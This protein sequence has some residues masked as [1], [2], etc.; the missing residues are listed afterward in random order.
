[1]PE[2]P[3]GPHVP[4]GSPPFPRVTFA[5]CCSATL[6][7]LYAI[8]TGPAVTPGSDGTSYSHYSVLAGIENAC[9]LSLLGGVATASPGPVPQRRSTGITWEHPG[10]VMISL[11]VVSVSCDNCVPG[12]LGASLR[13]IPACL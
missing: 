10:A 5:E 9:G 11:R 12:F 7:P 8:E 1:M 13:R 6:G 4:G 3:P 2:G